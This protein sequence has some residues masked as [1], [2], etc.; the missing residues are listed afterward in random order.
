MKTRAELLDAINAWSVGTGDLARLMAALGAHEKAVRAEA[1][2]VHRHEIARAV[3]LPEDAPGHEVVAAVRSYVER[4]KAAVERGV[5]I[6]RVR[7]EARAERDE[8][9]A[10]AE[11]AEA[12][13]AALRKAAGPHAA[14]EY[15]SDSE[16]RA[17][18]IAL[19]DAEDAAEAHDRRVRAEAL[20]EAAAC[21]VDGLRLWGRKAQGDA[22]EWL[23]ARADE[24]EE[25][26]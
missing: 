13:L 17:L 19:A 18:R 24:I 26:R 5:H 2:L 12:A 9:T 10:R 8:A 20:R 1:L 15:A 23:R 22:S 14:A 11:R 25:G 7:E 6:A 3:G 16:T 21:T 4:Y